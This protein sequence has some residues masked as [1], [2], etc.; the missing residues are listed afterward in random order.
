MCGRYL[1]RNPKEELQDFFKFSS[2]EIR[3][4]NRYNVAPTQSVPVVRVA[5]GNREAVICR[6]GLIPGWATKDSKL[7]IMINARSE[8]IATK[9][10][11]K[12]AFAARRCIF[13]ASG[14]YEWRADAARLKQP[15]MIARTDGKPLAL[16]GIWER[17]KEPIREETISGAIVTTAAAPELSE[18]HDRMPVFLPEESWEQWLAGEPLA[19]SEAAGLFQSALPFPMTA[20]PVSRL[21]NSIKNDGPELLQHG[22]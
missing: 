1:I 9:G 10:S 18:I 5:D 11:F 15:F 16:A 12:K 19:E 13:P 17:L 6:W 7:P 2:S 20:R 14:Y 22:P 4:S 21:V 8:S 3:L